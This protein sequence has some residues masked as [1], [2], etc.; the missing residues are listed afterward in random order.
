MRKNPI[1][2]LVKK[3]FLHVFRDK[4]LLPVVFIVPL[5][6]L[7]MFGYVV[8]TDVKNLSVAVV[9]YDRG[10]ESQRLINQIDATEFFEIKLYPKSEKQ[11]EE[12]ILHGKADAGIVFPK[13][14]SKD[15]RNKSTSI[16][17]VVDGSDPNAGNVALTYLS[18]I[19]RRRSV[20]ILA[21]KIPKSV[22]NR[23]PG[24][25]PSIRVWYNPNLKSVNFMI[26]G[27]I[28]F[29]LAYVTI[30]LTAV[31]IVKEKELGTF[32]Q[33]IVTPLKRYE[34]L[35][36]KMI[37]FIILGFFDT[38]LVTLVGVFW[39][40]IPFR[41]SVFI[42]LLFS[43]LFLIGI[44][45]AGLFASTV[46]RTQQQAMLSAMLFMIASMLL[47]GFIFPV[48][49]MPKIIRAISYIIPLTYFEYVLRAIFLKGVG[50]LFLWQAGL[51][52]LSLGVLIFLLSLSRFK[53]RFT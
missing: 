36:G 5:V 14:F 7:I 44:L 47:S 25:E 20:E 38:I 4:G 50:F 45:G 42:F 24:I 11:L 27:L 31:A 16:Q 22:Q 1:F 49:N 21:K 13:E 48:E 15:A 12:L 46:S 8:S 19:V 41:G 51:A 6:Q 10:Q 34:L 3:E 17:I 26:P 9:D 2:Y 33:L 40:Q 39:F 28:G 53:K 18:T 32:E 43:F 35:L 29:I 30:I 52:L 37:P 23:V